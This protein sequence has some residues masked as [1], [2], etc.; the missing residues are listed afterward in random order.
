MKRMASKYPNVHAGM[1]VRKYELLIVQPNNQK[2]RP[3]SPKIL[4][5]HKKYSKIS[6]L[7][8]ESVSLP[9]DGTP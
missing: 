1:C 4:T 5:V 3:N 7:L 8:K 2:R 9:I 6:K